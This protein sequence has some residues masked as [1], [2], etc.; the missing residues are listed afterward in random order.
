MLESVERPPV[1][2]GSPAPDPLSREIQFRGSRWF[3]V[4]GEEADLRAG[5]PERDRLFLK[6]D[7]GAL[8]VGI[9]EC[10]DEQKPHRG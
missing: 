3:C 8:M 4:V 2:R 7:L 1:L 5:G 10:A 6:I 9:G